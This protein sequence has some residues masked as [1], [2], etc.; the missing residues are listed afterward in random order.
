MGKASNEKKDRTCTICEDIRLRTAKEMKAHYEVC[1]AE[2]VKQ[3]IAEQIKT[4]LVRP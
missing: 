3:S 2:F 1:L 4:Q